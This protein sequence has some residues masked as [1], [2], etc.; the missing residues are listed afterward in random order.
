MIRRATGVV[1]LAL[2]VTGTQAIIFAI[3]SKALALRQQ[4]GYQDPRDDIVW[5]QQNGFGG[6]HISCADYIQAH[7]HLIAHLPQAIGRRP[8]WV[9]DPARTEP[10]RSRDFGTSGFGWPW[11]AVCLDWMI[12]D[13]SVRYTNGVVLDDVSVNHFPP[14]VAVIPTRVRPIAFLG[15][16][17]IVALALSAVYAIMQSV[18]RH[19]RVRHRCCGICGYDLTGIAVERC[20]ECGSSPS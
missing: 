12:V 20:P 7:Q 17:A 15:N 5:I 3:C 4:A 14:R 19:V 11:R 13:G 16:S 10:R 8:A 2:L 18:I 6:T 1:V 9:Q